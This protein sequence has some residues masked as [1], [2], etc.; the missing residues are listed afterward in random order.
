[1]S[2]TKRVSCGIISIVES[3]QWANLFWCGGTER[4]SWHRVNLLPSM[5]LPLRNQSVGLEGKKVTPKRISVLRFF[6]RPYGRVENTHDP[7]KFFSTHN[8]SFSSPQPSHPSCL[9]VSTSSLLPLSLELSLA[10]VIH[11]LH[12]GCALPCKRFGWGVNSNL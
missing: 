10:L 8:F 5:I 12:F 9:L 7:L 2:R 4:E 6:L 11:H 1:V 3:S